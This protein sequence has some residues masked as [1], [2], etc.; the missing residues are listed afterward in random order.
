MIGI[1]LPF[2]SSRNKDRFRTRL[3]QKLG[4]LETKAWVSSVPPTSIPG[5]YQRWTAQP[6]TT[7]EPPQFPP[8]SNKTGKKVSTE[9]GEPFTLDSSEFQDQGE[10]LTI[11]YNVSL[12]QQQVGEAESEESKENDVGNCNFTP[13]QRQDE[14]SHISSLPSKGVHKKER[15][16]SIRFDSEV[17]VI[18]IPSHSEYSKNLKEFIWNSPREIQQNASRNRREFAAEGWN[19]RNVVEEDQ[20][21]LDRSSL[22]FIHPVHLGG[23]IEDLIW[24]V[25]KWDENSSFLH[26]FIFIKHLSLL[27]W[28]KTSTT[29]FQQESSKGQ[30][31]QAGGSWIRNNFF[32][33][34]SIQ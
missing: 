15:K 8:S 17:R 26:F 5:I 31:L 24:P 34:E 2:E 32:R 30:V 21:Y 22:E 33:S 7:S 11:S 28:T 14:S 10:V 3:I 6:S 9:L 4:I 19:W 25:M 29:G 1:A 13:E 18:S 20:M 27:P 12:V 23:S 16:R